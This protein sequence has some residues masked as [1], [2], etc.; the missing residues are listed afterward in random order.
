[1]TLTLWNVTHD[2]EMFVANSLQVV[3]DMKTFV[4]TKN[5]EIMD[6]KKVLFE[7]SQGRIVNVSEIKFCGFVEVHHSFA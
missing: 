5:R 6:A 4:A 7:T 2:N 3:R 1:M